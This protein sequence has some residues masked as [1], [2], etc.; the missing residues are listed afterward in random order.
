MPHRSGFVNIIGRPN[1][2]KSSLMNALVGEKLSAI[3]RKA[4]TTRHRILGIVS[5]N[6]YQVVFSDTPGILKPHYKL[7][8][9]MMKQ[10]SAAIEDADLLIYM[11][12][13]G[14]KTGDQTEIIP[15]ILSQQTPLF[16]VVNK[17][18]QSS[19]ELTEETLQ[20][21]RGLL[22]PAQEFQI[23]A[24]YGL[25]VPY[26]LEK[27]IAVLPESPP[28]YSKD[29]LTDRPLRFFIAEI[30]REKALMLYSKEVPYCME[31]IVDA[32]KE[33]DGIIKIS[34]TL[35]VARESQKG[36]VLGHKGA[37]IK[38]LGTVSRKDIEAF[39]GK[40]VFLELSV[41]VK[42]NWRDNNQMLKHFGYEL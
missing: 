37:A 14:E 2:G 3:T 4:Q 9:W 35:F 32:Y 20:Q 36:I 39:I 24:L 33:S 7:H 12:E 42:D 23:S 13:A 28:W 18:D 31:V 34:A 11:V 27:I 30:I 5:S 17:I 41:K 22:N 21:W 26:L 25:G 6:D 16:L 29:E 10:V 40:H 15:E 19:P 8:E 1:V 38:K